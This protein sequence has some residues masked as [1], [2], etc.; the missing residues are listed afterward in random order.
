[1][2]EPLDLSSSNLH[3]GSR[4]IPYKVE[5]TGEYQCRWAMVD[6][7]LGKHYRCVEDNGHGNMHRTV[8]GQR[9]HTVLEYATAEDWYT[10]KRHQSSP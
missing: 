5:Y 2:S 4:Y 1:M 6:T 9:F 7:K 10:R 8:T 3:L